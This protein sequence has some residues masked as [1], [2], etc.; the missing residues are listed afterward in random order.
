MGKAGSYQPRAGASCLVNDCK[1]QLP[2]H[3]PKLGC[4]T[5]TPMGKGASEASTQFQKAGDISHPQIIIMIFCNYYLCI[6]HNCH[7]YYHQLISLPSQRALLPSSALKSHHMGHPCLPLTAVSGRVYRDSSRKWDGMLLR[8][9]FC[10]AYPCRI[11]LGLGANSVQGPGS[12]LGQET[13][14]NERSLLAHLF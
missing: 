3:S 2:L 4:D 5:R 7:N 11:L 1:P 10:L 14:G 12:V 13:K 6:L 8:V 9:L